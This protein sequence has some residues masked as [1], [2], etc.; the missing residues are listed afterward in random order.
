MNAILDNHERIMVQMDENPWTKDALHSAARLARNTGRGIILVDMIPAGFPSW[1]GTDMGNIFRLPHPD[2]EDWKA[3]LEDYGV[4][5]HIGAFR[6]IGLIEGI[7]QAAE[8]FEAHVVFAH[9][10]RSMIPYWQRFQRWCLQRRLSQN[11]CQLCDTDTQLPSVVDEVP[12]S[13][14]R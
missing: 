5:Y 12:V 13:I 6:Y 4:E 1:L 7:A 3:T 14:L 11:Q 8:H 2:L 9:V 10:P